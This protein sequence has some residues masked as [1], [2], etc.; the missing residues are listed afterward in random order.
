M[1]TQRINIFAD[2][3]ATRSPQDFV[4]RF[5]S[6]AQTAAGRPLSLQE[7]RVTTS[8][9]AVA[10]AIANLY[11]GTPQNWQTKTDETT[12]VYTT[13]S[14]MKIILDGP[15]S[16]SSGLIL[17]GRN[18]Q[19]IRK[20]DGQIQGDPNAGAACVC[21]SDINERRE[22]A[23]A[24]SGCDISISLVFRLA[25]PEARDLGLWRFNSSSWTL[26][27]EIGSATSDL[28]AL[29]GPAL[30]ELSLVQ[31]SY[32]TRAGQ[33]REFTK[34]VLTILGPADNG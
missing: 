15:E 5:R 20:C 29:D 30:A 19:P 22:A 4:G 12:E 16:V 13:E 28:D 3:K 10:D 8:D 24:G 25:D 17:W 26:A 21:P 18:N 9:P 6:G 32:E 27:R 7:W 34:P 11:G 2:Q 31:V 1:A 33:R 14:S 23:K